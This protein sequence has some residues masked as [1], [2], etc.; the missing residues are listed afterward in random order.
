M[1]QKLIRK[2]MTTMAAIGK[3]EYRMHSKFVGLYKEGVMFA[4]VQ[5]TELHLFNN[6]I[7]VK[8]NHSLDEEAFNT[9]LQKA[10]DDIL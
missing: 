5:A 3:V 6:G 10:Y 9:E 8:V 7:L 4:K 1:E 2:I